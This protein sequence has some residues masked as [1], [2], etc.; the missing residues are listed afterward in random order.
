MYLKRAEEL[1]LVG[2]S[3]RLRWTEHEMLQD[4]AGRM[5]RTPSDVVR[6]LIRRAAK[7]QEL[8]AGANPSHQREAPHAN[9]GPA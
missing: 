1:H 3:V 2:C 4:L 6:V 8:P 7:A 9:T 5:E